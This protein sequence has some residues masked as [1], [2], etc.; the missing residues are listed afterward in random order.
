MELILQLNSFILNLTTLKINLFNKKFFL[1]VCPKYYTTYNA[2]ESIQTNNP[3]KRG[4]M[5]TPHSFATWSFISFFLIILAAPFLTFAATLSLSPSSGTQTIGTTF[6]V[7]ISLDTQTSPIDGV[8]IRYL[9]YNPAIL[10]VQDAN[11]TT[12]G[13]QITAGNLM[14]QTIV[15]NVDSI[16]GLISFSQIINT[17]G[18]QFNGS[19]TFATITFKALTTG[20]ANINFNFTSGNTTDS[21][22]TSNG[23]D[24]LTSVINGSY[25]LISSSPIL[26]PTPTPAPIPTPTATP[27]PTSATT[28]T[29][30]SSSGGGGGGGSVIT[31]T[32]STPTPTISL[33]PTPSTTSTTTATSTETSSTT[34]GI[35]ITNPVAGSSL[36]NTIIR[37]LT[38]QKPDGILIAEGETIYDSTVV[39]SGLLWDV[40]NNRVKFEIELRKS[41]EEFTGQPIIS[42]LYYNSGETAKI[43]RGGLI[44]GSYRFK[45]R[46]KNIIEE[47]SDWL[48]FGN[49]S[50]RDFIISAAQPTVQISTPI[51]TP[52][53]FTRTLRRGIKG[54][55]V[56]QFQEELNILGYNVG[57]ADGSFGRKTAAVV[58]EFQSKYGLSADGL[59]G[60]KSQTKFNEIYTGQTSTASI[61]TTTKI[62][63]TRTLLIGSKGSDVKNLQ[64]L[65]NSLGFTAGTPDGSFGKKTASAVIMFQSKYGLSADGVFGSKSAQK[66]LEVIK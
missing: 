65:L 54:D 13:I 63:F 18:V 53:S 55:D 22:I 9:N 7:N 27:T 44:A 2:N 66:L 59:F 35:T 29:S 51:R 6:Q 19:G 60:K 31:T 16:S 62:E 61:A 1:F 41:G 43:E 57:L 47:T 10:E 8:D 64:G 23:S 30:S 24:I 12:A 3:A 49:S 42:S 39:F 50:A 11:T 34:T 52:I 28:T 14:P 40:N 15:N 45:A 38:Q 25:T 4:D 36:T 58:K 56:K 21:N 33:T 5:E 46:T 20:T 37:N 48:E 32:T 26:T 17:G